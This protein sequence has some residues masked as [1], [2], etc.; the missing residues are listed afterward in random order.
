VAVPKFRFRKHSSLGAAAAEHDQE[1]LQECFVDTGDL[2]TLADCKKPQRIVVGRTGSGKTALLDRL[3]Q[4]DHAISIQ[5]ESL[6]LTHIANSSV[7]QFFTDAGLKIDIFLRLLWRHVFTVELIRARYAITNEASKR[8]ALDRLLEHLGRDKGKRRALDYIEQWGDRF[9][10]TTEYRIKE[11][12]KRIESDLSSSIAAGPQP[13]QL[14]ATSAARLSEEQRADV[15]ERGQKVIDQ[16]QIKELSEIVDL[17]DEYVFDDPQ[18]PYYI[19]IDR[20]D[21]NWIEDRF[22]YLLIRSLLETIRDFQKLRYVKIVIVLRSDLLDRVFRLTRDAG[23]Q[24]EKFRALYLKLRWSRDQLMSCI[25]RRVGYLVRQTYTKMGAT[26]KDV[27][28]KSVG[29]MQ[30]FDYMVERTLRRP[31]EL[32][33]FFNECI[34]LASETPAITRSM[35]LQAEGVYSKNR[36][37]SLQEEWFADYPRLE[38]CLR[39]LRGRPKNFRVRSLEKKEFEDFC[40]EVAAADPGASDRM[41][42]V[43]RSVAECAIGAQAGLQAVLCIFYQIGAVGLK[44]GAADG[45]VWA[46]EGV[47]GIAPESITPDT[48]VSI[49]PMLYRALGVAP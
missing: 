41:S 30:V 32:I 34:E 49:H 39:F 45:V 20:L 5:P 38:E 16:I 2:A 29:E 43:A 21:E 11:L 13:F 36:A 9:W 1:Y 47:V 46:H 44:L 7:L 35:L 14:N 19:C 6:S 24:E 40:L 18:K 4:L 27:L 12:V 33:E 42:S 37:R 10:E 22:R 3:L 17:L 26:H 25:D 15:V 8:N 28:P 23:F 48:R 31:R